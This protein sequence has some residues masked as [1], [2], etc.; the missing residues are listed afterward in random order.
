MIRP[1][2]KI[3][4]NKVAPLKIHDGQQEAPTRKRRSEH[5]N[6]L[7]KIESTAAVRHKELQHSLNLREVK[8]PERQLLGRDTSVMLPPI[9]N[10]KPPVA[11]SRH[12]KMEQVVGKK[13]VEDL[14]NDKD[15]KARL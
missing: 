4:I 15:W 8:N 12:D 3:E 13:I 11:T 2:Q 5:R 6:S 7:K 9:T 14:K 1:D 10:M